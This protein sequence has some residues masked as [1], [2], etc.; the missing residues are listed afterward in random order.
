MTRPSPG[1]FTRF[2]VRWLDFLI[3][4]PH[5]GVAPAVLCFGLSVGVGVGVAAAFFGL[6]VAPGELVGDAAAAGADSPSDVA[7]PPLPVCFPAPSATMAAAATTASD[8]SPTAT[9]RTFISFRPEAT[10][11]G[12]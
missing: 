10:D 6:D 8:S 7:R 12:A 3:V 5:P 2:V 11:H 1:Q 4:S 9:L